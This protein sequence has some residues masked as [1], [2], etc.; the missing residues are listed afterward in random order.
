MLEPS[1]LFQRPL[2]FKH[3]RSA[4]L[5]N[6][7]SQKSM[8]LNLVCP[9]KAKQTVLAKFCHEPNA[10][11]QFLFVVVAFCFGLSSLL[12]N[13]PALNCLPPVFTLAMLLWTPTCKLIVSFDIPPY[14]GLRQIAY[15]HDYT[16]WGR[17]AFLCVIQKNCCTRLGEKIT[18]VLMSFLLLWR[19]RN[20]NEKAFR[21]FRLFCFAGFL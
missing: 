19:L 8:L 14:L 15:L 4:N 13:G 6:Q 16:L 11:G 20:W 2:A 3:R 10:R 1:H 5:P 21:C 12:S 9:S 18:V 17:I 7:A